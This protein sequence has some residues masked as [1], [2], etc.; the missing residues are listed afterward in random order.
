MTKNKDADI[1]YYDFLKTLKYD[2]IVYYKKTGKMTRM[3][4]KPMTI[5]EARTI[6][7]RQSRESRESVFIYQITT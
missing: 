2:L 6:L 7:S 3:N 1:S 5:C 4:L